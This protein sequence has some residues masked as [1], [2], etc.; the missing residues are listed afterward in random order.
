MMR[1]QRVFVNRQL[2]RRALSTSPAI[3]HHWDTDGIEPI[4]DEI[5]LIMLC[6]PSRQRIGSKV[7]SESLALIQILRLDPGLLH[8][9]H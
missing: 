4:V 6:L 5:E 3:T 1:Q 7:E 2:V 8:H 9:H